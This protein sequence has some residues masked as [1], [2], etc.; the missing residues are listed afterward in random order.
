MGVKSLWFLTD[1]E[2]RKWS[3]GQQALGGWRP[4]GTIANFKTRTATDAAIRH[5]TQSEGKSHSVAVSPSRPSSRT[6]IQPVRTIHVHVGMMPRGHAKH[7][8][9]VGK[10][11]QIL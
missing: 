10:R 7:R 11:Q 3:M 2:R 8:S 4:E 6:C 9:R 1:P 5:G